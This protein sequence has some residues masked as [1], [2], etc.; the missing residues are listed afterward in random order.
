MDVY[1][2]YKQWIKNSKTKSK[3]VELFRNSYSKPLANSQQNKT[4]ATNK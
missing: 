2:R 3:S 4:G 1:K